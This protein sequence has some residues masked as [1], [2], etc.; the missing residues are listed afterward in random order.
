M[1]F[2]KSKLKN[3]KEIKELFNK[4]FSDSESEEEGIVI[5]DLVY[6]LI[7]NTDSEDLFVYNAVENEKIIGSIIFS[8]LSFEKSQLTAFLLG[9][10]AVHTDYQGRGIGQKLI[11]YGHDD[12]KKNGIKLVFT[13]GDINFY[14]KV[15]YNM[16]SE[17]KVKAPK[18]LSYSKG[19]LAQS[20]VDNEISP[21]SGNSYCV[22]AFNDP[23]YW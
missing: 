6:D 5:G 23:K 8:R 14:S 21:I 7:S 20:L 4:T 3:I 1:K 15:G 17:E 13:Y 9:P 16:I 2:L 12:L 18:K 19:W 11:N 22:D 10:V